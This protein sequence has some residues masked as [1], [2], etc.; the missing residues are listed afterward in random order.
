[1]L[2]VVI[3]GLQIQKSKVEKKMLP[4][5]A[6]QC[7]GKNHLLFFSPDHAYVVTSRSVPNVRNLIPWLVAHQPLIALIEASSLC[8][9]FCRATV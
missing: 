7:I 3:F 6:F 4:A 8:L 1:M 9:F 5:S 2:I